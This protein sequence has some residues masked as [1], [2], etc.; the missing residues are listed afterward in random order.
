MSDYLSRPEASWANG[1]HIVITNWKDMTHSEAGGAESY[2][3]EVAQQLSR[4]GAEV[5]LLTA[6][7]RGAKRRERVEFGTIVRR[8]GRFTTYPLGMLWLLV[9]R[10]QVDAV[11]DSQSGISYFSPL[12]L[13]SRT[14]VILL[15]HHVHQEQFREYFPP[16]V[17][18]IG[19]LL[20]KEVSR[21]VYRNRPICAVSPS[22]RLEIRRSLDLTN[23]IFITPNALSESVHS[24]L[25]EQLLTPRIRSVHPTLTCVG[26]LVPHKRHALLLATLQEVQA[27]HKDLQV[28]IIGDGSESEQLIE[29]TRDLGLLDV[30]KFHGHLSVEDRD[31]L[32]ATSWLNV[33]TSAREGWGMSAI[34][35]AAFG[36]PTV[37]LAVPGLRDSV[38]N[39]RTGWLIEAERDLTAGLLDALDVVN[40][41]AEAKEWSKRCIKWAQSFSWFETTARILSILSTESTARADDRERRLISDLAI[42]LKIPRDKVS[43]TSLLQLRRVDQVREVGD[44]FE[45]LLGGPD[46]QQG[47]AVLERLG[48]EHNEVELRLARQ[49]D[50]LGW[51]SRPDSLDRN[52]DAGLP[53]K[54]NPEM[55]KAHN[56][57]SSPSGN[58]DQPRANRLHILHLAFEDPLSPWRGG[59]SI[60]NHEINKRLATRHQVTAVVAK[61]PGSRRRVQDGI[62]YVPI[63]LPFGR[64]IGIISYHLALPLYLFLHGSDLVVEDFGAPHSSDLVPILTRRPTIAVVQYLFAARKSEQYH[65]P[66]WCF[67]EAGLRIHSHF[68]AVSSTVSARIAKSNPEADI[69]V[70]YAGVAAPI[71]SLPLEKREGLLFLGRF[72][73]QM[74]G[75][76]LLVDAFIQISQEFPDIRLKIAGSGPDRTKLAALLKSRGLSER[77]DWLGR[78]DGSAKWEVLRRA[79]LVLMPSR[80]ETFGL[81]AL[82][83]LA[84]GTPVVAFDIPPLHELAADSGAILLVHEIDGV[85]LGRAACCLLNDPVQWCDMSVAGKD[86]AE[87]FTWEAAARVHEQMY[88][89]AAATAKTHPL[90]RRLFRLVTQLPHMLQRPQ[91]WTA[92]S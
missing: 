78:L 16:L 29:R 79:S 61:H 39:G 73:Y 48:L 36:V 80:F 65:L 68:I 50:L 46:E 13:S 57:D 10:R 28:H 62:T 32:V 56:T 6:R 15:V 72:E 92:T 45:I 14:P 1:R 64:M 41:P 24:R 43:P 89:D 8:G 88:Y 33:S 25:D 35:A 55:F 71:D 47:E 58:P 40:H 77:V 84:V 3:E 7:Q 31:A 12:V 34:E 21:Y 26:R 30:V 59:G 2:C 20:E 91:D 74:K 42:I 82:E 44:S 19:R 11:I 38:Q 22:T 9:R 51:K 27:R 18:T 5:T 81:V 76:D 69:R 52:S 75:L 49:R 85:D 4:F 66:F 86:R 90:Q 83:A 60:R 23:P 87:M 67:E 37:A 53:S 70:A 17:A 63:G 54:I